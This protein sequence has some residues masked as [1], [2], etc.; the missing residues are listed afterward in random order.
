MNQAGSLKAGRLLDQAQN[1]K[2]PILAL[3]VCRLF[4]LIKLHAGKALQ[5]EISLWLFSANRPKKAL[6]LI[7]KLHN[8][9]AEIL[10][11]KA[12]ALREGHI[13]NRQTILDLYNTALQQ[14]PSL[15]LGY[16]GK[17]RLFFLDFGKPHEAL[18][19]YRIALNLQKTA[20]LFAEAAVCALQC[21][22]LRQ[23][24][25]WLEA[26]LDLHQSHSVRKLYA[27]T[28][29]NLDA[30]AKA[31]TSYRTIPPSQLSGYEKTVLLLLEQFY[32]SPE[33]A[34]NLASKYYRDKACDKTVYIFYF[35]YIK[36]NKLARK[37]AKNS[38]LAHLG[39]LSRLLANP[40]DKEAVNAFHSWACKPPPSFINCALLEMALF[41]NG[42]LAAPYFYQEADLPALYK[43]ALREKDMLK[44]LHLLNGLL[45]LAPLNSAA[46]RAKAIA[47]TRLG[48][49]QGA[50]EAYEQAFKLFPHPDW[51]LERAKELLAANQT[52]KAEN[53]IKQAQAS[54]LKRK[55]D[56]Q[57]LL[58]AQAL[59][60]LKQGL[61]KKALR[62]HSK[63][64]K[65]TRPW[66]K[67]SEQTIL[68]SAG[69]LLQAGK[70]K[71]ALGL[72]KKSGG[73]KTAEG[74]ELAAQGLI[75]L[76]RMQEA[77]FYQAKAKSLP[78]FPSLGNSPKRPFC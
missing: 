40:N 4:R 26:S 18:P 56:K 50:E 10:A 74:L 58:V 70:T 30:P 44:R 6:K 71:Q 65:A 52:E 34:K 9:T 29:L 41:I 66:H 76:G 39:A 38:G 69:F 23:A 78:Q 16:F 42:P 19:L 59:L 53:L 64:Q 24:K 3:L 55:K 47:Q 27:D 75:K 67:S 31:L 48:N 35:L 77:K 15:A 22:E 46:W 57:S 5:T 28:L 61:T 68:E 45:A 62:L 73:L 54:P 7:G 63:S 60:K 17:A 32:G 51:L 37:T 11:L 14:E 36:A 21:R 72:L 1:S 33:R 2:S 20:S 43:A 8:E 49:S 25:K 13:A 12:F